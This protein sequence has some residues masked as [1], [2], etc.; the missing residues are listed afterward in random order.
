MKNICKIL[1]IISLAV[2]II[3][4]C[5]CSSATK[6]EEITVFHAGSLSVPFKQIAKEYMRIYPE[7]NVL[8]EASGSRQSA[9]KISELHRS[10]DIMASADYTVIEELLLPDHAT[11]YIQFANNEMCIAYTKKSV[12]GTEINLNNWYTVLQNEDVIYGR[13][14]PDTDPCG[15]RTLLLFQLAEQHYNI[16]GLAEAFFKKNTEYIRPMEVDLLALLENQSIDYIFIYKSVAL[17]HKL[18]YIGLPPAINLGDP[19]FGSFYAGASVTI[20]G[21]SPGET[22]T[23]TGEPMV[24]ALTI[25]VNASNYEGALRFANF[26]LDPAQGMRIIQENGQASLLPNINNYYDSIPDMLKKYVKPKKK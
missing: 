19:S 3:T 20:S 5:C 25:P 10:C 7:V 15:Y 23:K 2:I 16:P 26:I 17:Q 24:Y 12:R 1:P 8:L 6:K 21:K 13:S 9:R 14:N 22:I 11:W 4:A 18:E